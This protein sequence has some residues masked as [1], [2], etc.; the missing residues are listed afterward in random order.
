[1]P[2]QWP[3]PGQLQPEEAPQHRKRLGGSAG[4]RGGG[5]LLAPPPSEQSAGFSAGLLHVGR[6]GGGQLSTQRKECLG[7]KKETKLK[8]VSLKLQI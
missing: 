8:N 2:L 5:V 1:M 7:L 3:R 4:G 6:S